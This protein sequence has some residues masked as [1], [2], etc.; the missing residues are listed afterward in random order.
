MKKEFIPL[1]KKER[2][3]TYGGFA[4]LALV[5]AIVTLT[6]TLVSSGIAIFQAIK[7]KTGSVSFGGSKT[8]T[9]KNP[10][11]TSTTKKNITS[12]NKLNISNYSAY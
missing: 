1:T 9:Q 2:V 6:Q 4:W 12:G 7:N 8:I 10:P 5:P 3:E 11:N